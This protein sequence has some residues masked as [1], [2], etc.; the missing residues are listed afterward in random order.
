MEN[1]SCNYVINSGHVYTSLNY[2]GVSL[3]LCMI[4]NMHSQA[5]V[6]HHAVQTL[7]NYPGNSLRSECTYQPHGMYSG[8]SLHD[9]HTY[10]PYMEYQ[11]TILT[12]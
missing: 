9:G 6:Y 1:L 3:A 12:V 7:V 5:S 10:Q 2:P 11:K 8:Y 4:P